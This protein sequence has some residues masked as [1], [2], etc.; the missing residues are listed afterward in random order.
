MGTGAG[1]CHLPLPSS[2]ALNPSPAGHGLGKGQLGTC[3]PESA[4]TAARPGGSALTQ[5]CGSHRDTLAVPMPPPASFGQDPSSDSSW[6]HV[7]WPRCWVFLGDLWGHEWIW[8][9]KT[10][11]ARMS[12][13]TTV[14]VPAGLGDRDAER[15]ISCPQGCRGRGRSHVLSTVVPVCPIPV[16]VSVR[17]LFPGLMPGFGGCH[18]ARGARGQEGP[19]S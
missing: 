11:L 13:G 14:P 1:T 15:G 16:P 3:S 2:V 18:M 6:Y 9:D 10:T 7:P 19:L 8:G 17:H 4:R 5:S 12:L